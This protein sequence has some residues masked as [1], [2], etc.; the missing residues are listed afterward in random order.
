MKKKTVLQERIEHLEERKSA[1]ANTDGERFIFDF[2]IESLKRKL[3]KERE[4]I[5][6]AYNCGNLDNDGFNPDKLGEQYY[7]E[8]FG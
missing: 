4:Q 7:K 2:C 6:E 1:L 5:E 8:T 3:E